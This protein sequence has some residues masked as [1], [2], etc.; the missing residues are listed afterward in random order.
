MVAAG[1]TQS[2]YKSIFTILLFGDIITYS[3]GLVVDI[4]LTHAKGNELL[5]ADTLRYR[6][7][8]HWMKHPHSFKEVEPTNS[9]DNMLNDKKPR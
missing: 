5:L 8:L 3:G 2:D 7:R 4:A 6:T 9:G 1:G